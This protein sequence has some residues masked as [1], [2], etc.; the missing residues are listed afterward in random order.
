MSL[1]LLF[2]LGQEKNA[3]V[4]VIGR[5]DFDANK[6][7]QATKYNKTL[8]SPVNHRRSTEF[9]TITE[10]CRYFTP[11][12]TSKIRYYYVLHGLLRFLEHGKCFLKLHLIFN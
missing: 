5:V 8:S 10:T 11:M 3:L 1:L 9:L 7:M 6:K 2:F 12:L 4:V